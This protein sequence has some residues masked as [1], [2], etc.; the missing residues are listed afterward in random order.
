MSLH[1]QGA[2]MGA[3]VPRV[4]ILNTAIQP[5]VHRGC[6]LL[7]TTLSWLHFSA[8]PL[9]S[10]ASV[11]TDLS[12]WLT[13]YLSSILTGKVSRGGDGSHFDELVGV[14]MIWITCQVF[15][16]CHNLNRSISPLVFCSSVASILQNYLP[17]MSKLHQINLFR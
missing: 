15:W 4:L 14:L 11:A 5:L 8:K 13:N 3:A 6:S 7:T 16:A 10:M 2:R 17:E 12:K 1:L 9:T